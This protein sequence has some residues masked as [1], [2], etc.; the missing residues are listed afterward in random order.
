[1]KGRMCV[2]GCVGVCVS[3]CAFHGASLLEFWAQKVLISL[4]YLGMWARVCGLV[5][6]VCECAK[7]RVWVCAFECEF[8]VGARPAI[9]RVF[10]SCRQKQKHSCCCL[11]HGIE[12]S[13]TDWLG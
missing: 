13:M 3:V 4:T 9:P 1:M 6:R 10:L 12:D 5:M 2:W 11:L 7:M 8:K